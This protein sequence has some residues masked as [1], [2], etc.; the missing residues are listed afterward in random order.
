MWT[1]TLFYR[2]SED[3]FFDSSFHEAV[4][5]ILFT[6]ITT[7]ASMV[8]VKRQDDLIRETKD[9]RMLRN[10]LVIMRIAIFTGGDNAY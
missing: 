8:S 5:L 2:F 9:G 1:L 3:D 6:G 7:H 4:I 10:N